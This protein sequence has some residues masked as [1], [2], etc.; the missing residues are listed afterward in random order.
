MANNQPSFIDQYGYQA[1]QQDTNP[2]PEDQT[3]EFDQNH[4]SVSG[5]NVGPLSSGQKLSPAT[6]G[7]FAPQQ[8]YTPEQELDEPPLLEELDIDIQSIKSN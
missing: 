6:S 2:W 7:K 4:P 5:F 8:D 3:I 1:S